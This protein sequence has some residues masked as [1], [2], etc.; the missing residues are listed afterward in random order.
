MASFFDK[1]KDVAKDLT[2]KAKATAVDNAD[3]LDGAVDKAA[4]FI[5]KKTKGKYSDK[6]GKATSAAHR[7][8]DKLEAEK[9]KAE[10]RGV[11]GTVVPDPPV[12]QPDPGLHDTPA[13]PP[14]AIDPDPT[15]AQADPGL[16]DTPAPPPSAI[17][18]D[19]TVAKPD[20]GAPGPG[21]PDT[22]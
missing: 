19:P 14:S 6:V 9:R 20:P 1:A 22:P 10:G 18:P 2:G 17:D 15:V 5:D 4:G 3:K 7:A 8:V 11:A 13:P 12:A 16:H 21:T